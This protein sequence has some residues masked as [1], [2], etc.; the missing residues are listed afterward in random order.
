MSTYILK[1]WHFANGWIFTKHGNQVIFN[2]E[3][4]CYVIFFSKSEKF[5]NFIK[6]KNVGSFISV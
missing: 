4:A 6:S 3:I 2:D 1:G 5:T